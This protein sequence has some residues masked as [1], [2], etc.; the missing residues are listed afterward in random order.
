MQIDVDKQKVMHMGKD[1][2]SVADRVINSELAVQKR[3]LGMR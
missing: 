2:A 3:D 1:N